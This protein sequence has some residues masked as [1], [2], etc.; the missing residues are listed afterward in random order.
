MTG[1][2]LAGDS[3]LGV[4]VQ[5]PRPYPF[6]R[7]FPDKA[8]FRTDILSPPLVRANQNLGGYPER[9]TVR[10]VDDSPHKIRPFQFPSVG[11]SALRGGG[12]D[13]DLNKGI[14]RLVDLTSHLST[15]ARRTQ[16]LRLLLSVRRSLRSSLG[17]VGL[18]NC[19]GRVL[20]SLPIR[21]CVASLGLSFILGGTA[22]D[23]SPVIP[24]IAGVH[25]GRVIVGPSFGQL[26]WWYLL[27][28]IC[29]APFAC[30]LARL[31]KWHFDH[32]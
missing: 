3:L 2:R 12:G 31:L 15:L 6:S 28:S 1:Q 30:L 11:N 26:F 22:C 8:T 20:N 32:E 23:G 19:F 17:H 10:T 5:V 9:A 14:S 27:A 25:F 29:I 4:G 16:V 18:R 24:S 13:L 21:A 7:G